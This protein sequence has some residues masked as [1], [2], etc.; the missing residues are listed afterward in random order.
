MQADAERGGQFG[1]VGNQQPREGQLFRQPHPLFGVARA[2]TTTRLPC[3]SRRAAAAQSASRSSV[4]NTSGMEHR[5]GERSEAVGRATK[6]QVRLRRRC[7]WTRFAAMTIAQNLADILAR[8]EAARKAAVKP[9]PAT[10]L[11]AVS[12]T[13]AQAGVREALDA[14]QRVFGENRVQEAQGKF[15][16]LKSGLPGPGAVPDRAAADQQGERGLRFV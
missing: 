9:A 7:C 3:G 2:R 14:G 13:V 8:I 12:K 15:P 5:P 1:I 4:I 6:Q 11:V 10:Q 16:A